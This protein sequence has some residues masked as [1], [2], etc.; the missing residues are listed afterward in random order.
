[1][2]SSSIGMT[3]FF[4][5]GPISILPKD[6]LLNGVISLPFICLFLMNTMFGFRI[7]CIESTFFTSYRYQHI[8]TGTEYF[9]F[10]LNEKTI[11]SII[12]TEYRLLAYLTPSLISFMINII[13]LHFTGITFTTYV[14][15]YPQIF[16]ASCFTPFMFKGCHQNDQYSI[17]IWKFGTVLNAIFIGC[18]PQMIL[19]G[20]DYYTGVIYWDFVGT[21]LAGVADRRYENNDALFKHNFGN[22][23]FAIASGTFFLVLIVFVFFTE[24]IFKNHG[25]YCKFCNILCSPCPQSCFNLSKSLSVSP[26]TKPNNTENKSGCD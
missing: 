25:I 12:P 20:M 11:D 13:K 26:I 15:K 23:I 7:I 6:S 9:P 10:Q 4:L 5:L 17:K 22:S 24:R 19:V 21:H 8:H 18:L 3:K 2:I 16:I 14:K 1:M